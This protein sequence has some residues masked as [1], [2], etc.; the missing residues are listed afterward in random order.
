MT[1][2]R[3]L[4]EFAE[5]LAVAGMSERTVETYSSYAARFA[6]FLKTYYSRIGSFDHSLYRTAPLLFVFLR[7]RLWV[8]I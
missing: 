1:F 3:Y 8:D 2:D 4:T 5:Y 6:S 7:V